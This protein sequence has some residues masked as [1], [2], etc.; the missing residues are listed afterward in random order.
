MIEW[1]EDRLELP[2]S[3]PVEALNAGLFVSS[4]RGRH[5]DRALDSNELIFVREGTLGMYEERRRYT[6]QAHEALLLREGRRHGGTDPYPD[7]LSFYWIHF[8]LRRPP[9]ARAPVHRVRLATHLRVG[10]PDLLTE[11]YRRFLDDQETGILTPAS[12]DLLVAQMLVELVGPPAPSSPTG[13]A[14]AT[15]ASRAVRHI[16]LQ[17]SGPLTASGIAAALRCHPDYL[18]RVFHQA[19]GQTLTQAIHTHRIRRAKACLLDGEL[20][21]KEVATVCGF[22]DAGYFRRIFHRAT[23]LTPAAF[24]L[25]HAHVHLNRE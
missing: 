23:G 4:G 7:D 19:Y 1:T 11:L 25:L 18:G 22:G 8:R 12:A 14:A 9:L 16:Q 10:R 6:V 17:G 21:I 3:P 20:S 2:L 24:R 5:P 13:G 15:L